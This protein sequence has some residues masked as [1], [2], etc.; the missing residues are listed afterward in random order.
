MEL[1]EKPEPSAKDES[2]PSNQKPVPSMKRQDLM[3]GLLSL[4]ETA[5]L[6]KHQMQKLC[7]KFSAGKKSRSSE[8]TDSE[9]TQFIQQLHKFL[10]MGGG[11]D[12]N[13]F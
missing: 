1:Q 5:Q 11:P 10:D 3:K 6:T 7:L 9:I 2:T 13:T 12:V 4:M 8:L